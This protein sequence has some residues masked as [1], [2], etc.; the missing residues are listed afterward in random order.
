MDYFPAFLNLKDKSCLLVGGGSVASRKAD[1][2]LAAGARLTV[3]APELEHKLRQ[4]VDSGQI[5]HRVGRFSPMDVNGHWLVVNASGDTQVSNEVFEA[6]NDAGVFCNSVDDKT[7]CSYVSPAIIDRSP[8]VVAVSSGG[9]APL[10]ARKI[11]AQ[12]ETI[13]PARLGQLAALASEWRDRVKN[14]IGDLLGRRRFWEEVFDGAVSDDALAGRMQS[15]RRNFASLLETATR[16]PK[17]DGE[18]WLVGAGPGDPGL[19]T[20]R[21]L[22]LMQRAD[23]VIHDR[24]VSREVLALVRRDAEIISVGKTPGCRSTSQEE[25]NELLIRLVSDGKRVCRLK[26]GDPF[27]FGRGGEEIEALAKAG[28]RYQVVPGITAAAGCAAYAGIPLTHRD[29]AQSVVFLTAHG[30]NSVDRL[31]WPSLARDRQ[32]LAIY[33]AVHRFPDIRSK[34]IGYGRSP[35]TPIAIIENGT[36]DKQRVIHG[37]LENLIDLAKQHEIVAPALLVIGE[38][39]AFGIGKEWFESRPQ[40]HE[41]EAP[42]S[43]A[44][45]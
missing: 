19:L 9:A 29:M 26:G 3:V 17:E 41:R 21:A 15:A 22:Q 32:T 2:L 33:M 39:A 34:L 40:V 28:L 16:S 27:I 31:D 30:K 36:S 18:A 10:L 12:I 38:V 25:I 8:V 45:L 5:T 13:L 35:D 1:L 42:A 20:L 43:V 24:L 6:A 4:Y 37:S 44:G 7:R 14:R 23:V 11:R